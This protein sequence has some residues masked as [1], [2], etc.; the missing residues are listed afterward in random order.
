MFTL[1]LARCGYVRVRE[2]VNSKDIERVYLCNVQANA[3]VGD[4]IKIPKEPKK[5]YFAQVGETY[6]TIAKKFGIEEQALRQ[7]NGDK[8]VYPTCKIYLP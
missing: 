5:I 6:F 2:G 7:E 1:I 4:I 3:K 8:I